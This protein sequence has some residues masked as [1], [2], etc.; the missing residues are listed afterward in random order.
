MFYQS[1]MFFN[2]VCNMPLCV[3]TLPRI[4]YKSALVSACLC[5]TKALSMNINTMCTHVHRRLNGLPSLVGCLWGA[6]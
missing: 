5:S 1:D 2:G 4:T 3:Q 6:D